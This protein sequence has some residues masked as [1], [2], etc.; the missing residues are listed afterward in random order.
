MKYDFSTVEKKWQEI[1]EKE[2]VFHATNDTS[3]PKFYALVEFP[4]PSGQGLHVGHPRSYTALDIIARKKRLQGYNVLYPMGW[5]A[6]GL[7]TENFAIKNHVH[8]AEVTKQNIA[9]FK[10]QLVS[11]GLSFDWSREINTTDPNYYKWTQWIF[12]KLFEKGLAYKKEMAVNWC[13][14][15]KC[16][17]ANEEVVNGVCERCGGEVVRKTKSQWMLGITKYA[18]RLIDDLDGV[19]YIERVKTQQRNWIGRSTGAEV[20][21]ETTSG[22]T[23]TVYTTRPDTL[24]GATYMVIS[25]EHPILEKWADKLHN[26][27]EVR[28]YQ[29]EAAS[30][31]DFERTEL[32]KDKTGVR[33][34][35]VEAINP[36]NGRQIPIFISD[37]VLISY[38]TGAIMAVPAH[39]TRDWEF[40]KKFNLPIIEVVK[41]GDVEKEAFTDCA[42]GVMVNSGMLDGLSVEDAKVK[43]VDW[44]EQEKKGQPKV[45]FKLRDWVFARQRYWGEPI[46]IV[47]CDKCG[48]VALPE[49]QLPLK[50]PEVESYE[51]TQ[52]GESPLAALT[53]WVN[54]TCPKCGDPA[55]RETDTMPQWAGSSWYFMRY[56]DPHNNDAL[57][58]KEALDYWLPVD[59][60]N[61]GMEHTTLH[62]LYSRFWHKFLYDIGVVSTP[63]PY[64]K[65][66][67]HGMILG[68]NGEKMSKSRGNVVNPDEIV[69]QYGADTMRLYE[70][71]IGDFEKSAPWSSK[72]IKGCKRFL[73]RIWDLQECVVEGGIR[74]ELERNFHKTIKKVTID[75]ENLKMN[76]AI[77]AMMALLN[78]I[79]DI[80]SITKEEFRTLLLLLN[81]FAPH[82]TEEL[83]QLVG[84]G[85]MVT[86][87]TWPTYDESKCVDDTVEIVLQI[88]GKV[89]NRLVIPADISKEDAIAA[90]KQD[91]KIASQI[92]GKTIVKEI[93]VPK[94]LVNLVVKG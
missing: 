14:S 80:G 79:S 82:I 37:Y 26:M 12:L 30:K 21:F 10:Q 33:L 66:T 56:C 1:W 81:P 90:A 49:D 69:N 13:N 70:M 22:D 83:W 71:F 41:G 24:F 35:G 74:P 67:S 57:A 55:H 7:P 50:L 88:N 9:R 54:T 36:V 78:D 38:G 51:P 2:G 17:L 85:G 32:V 64:A 43:I 68:E 15:C 29:A 40:A 31:S 59:W 3:R 5:D 11:L 8:P 75:I 65:R 60:Y 77:A 19:D 16:V 63:E 87:Q 52:N 18:Q 94:K 58:S 4:Y 89:R 62:L 72:S 23:L 84:F 27:D 76:T 25:P 6:F 93:Y 53:D 45:N 86:S 61:G 42:T 28:T 91:D 46:P 47:H 39:D 34:D 73:D 20:N 92:E 44:L 48:Y